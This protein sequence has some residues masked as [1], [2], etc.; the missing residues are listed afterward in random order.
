MIRVC[1]VLWHGGITT[2]TAWKT[3]PSRSRSPLGAAAPGLAGRQPELLVSSFAAW[4][5]A[6]AWVKPGLSRCLADA[7]SWRA[8][9]GPATAAGLAAGTCSP[10][11][12]RGAVPPDSPLV[13]GEGL[14]CGMEGG[15]G[16]L[17]TPRSPCAAPLGALWL[18]LGLSTS[19]SGKF[20]RWP[21]PKAPPV[22][23]RGARLAPSPAVGT[24]GHRWSP[25][26]VAE[27]GGAE[28]RR[29]A[30]RGAVPCRPPPR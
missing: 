26:A 24:L 2:G 14:R 6:K 20:S 23:S 11:D 30:W 21:L 8:G 1:P 4:Q 27:G 9:R 15:S 28:P 25:G 13:P 19:T 7:S 22:I 16:V 5:P 10:R 29:S 3:T 17:L 18:S 12:L